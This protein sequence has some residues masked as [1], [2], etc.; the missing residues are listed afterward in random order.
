VPLITLKNTG[1]GGSGITTI[2]NLRCRGF[3]C[4]FLIDTKLAAMKGEAFHV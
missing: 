2:F 3:A 1:T 4:R